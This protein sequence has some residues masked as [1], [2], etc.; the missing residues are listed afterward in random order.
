M[1]CCKYA[2]GTCNIARHTCARCNMPV[3]R[4]HDAL[5]NPFHRGHYATINNVTVYARAPNQTGLTFALAS[6]RA[7]TH[8]C[9]SDQES[10][11]L[12]ALL[13]AADHTCMGDK[14]RN[15]SAATTC[16]GRF[17]PWRS[18]MKGLKH[19]RNSF[20]KTTWSAT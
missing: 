15:K 1:S 9:H 7:G 10:F 11:N 14:Q 12:I 4:S 6:R 8:K 3:L 20:E 16:M 5:T 19:S 2:G 18:S 17:T 13:S